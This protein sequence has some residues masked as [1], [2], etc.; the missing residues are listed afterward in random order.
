[1]QKT[2][3]AMLLTIVQYT[4]NANDKHEARTDILRRMSSA[5][6]LTSW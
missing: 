2:S 1:M 3:R 5:S 6:R 4:Y